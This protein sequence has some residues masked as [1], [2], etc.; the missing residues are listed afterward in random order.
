MIDSD[1][2]IR[3]QVENANVKYTP[4][5]QNAMREKIAKDTEEFLANG[6]KITMLEV[7]ESNFQLMKFKIGS[8]I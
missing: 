3:F 6:G 4:E 8:A 5:Y 2:L 1:K 7:G